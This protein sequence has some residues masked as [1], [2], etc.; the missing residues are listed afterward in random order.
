[1]KKFTVLICLLLATSAHGSSL[2]DDLLN[3]IYAFPYDGKECVVDFASQ[4]PF[5]PFAGYGTAMI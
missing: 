5:Q 1:M 2:T 4:L 3:Y